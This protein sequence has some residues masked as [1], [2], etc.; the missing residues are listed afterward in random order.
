MCVCVIEII[1]WM[2]FIFSYF[3]GFD[4]DPHFVPLPNDTWKNGFKVTINCYVSI[5]S[6]NILWIKALALS[7]LSVCSIGGRVVNASS[8][9]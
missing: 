2:N 6:M 3:N 1:C 9:V 5:S 7:H 8:A 4:K